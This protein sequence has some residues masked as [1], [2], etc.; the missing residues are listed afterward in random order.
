MD[1]A[2]KTFLLCPEDHFSIQFIM[3]QSISKEI[4]SIKCLLF[5]K[6]DSSYLIDNYYP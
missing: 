2:V 1:F 3:V 5:I 4:L 6:K